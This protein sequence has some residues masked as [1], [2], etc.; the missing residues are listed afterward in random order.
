MPLE[1]VELAHLNVPDSP[2]IR[3]R[4]AE[5]THPGGTALQPAETY[6]ARDP[7]G[8]INPA[9]DAIRE[10]LE[11]MFKLI[12]TAVE[13]HMPVVS[14]IWQSFN[15]VE[16]VQQPVHGLGHKQETTH[17]SV[18]WTGEAATAYAL[19]YT[20]QHDAIS[21]V[22]TKADSVSKWLMDI[23]STTSTT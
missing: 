1:H 5:L 4:L 18:E 13:H 12:R 6:E 19:R 3:A 20:S 9:L 23:A 11:K 14:L 15:W 10:A 8:L 2:Q 22:A 7:A 17:L 16:K 21:A